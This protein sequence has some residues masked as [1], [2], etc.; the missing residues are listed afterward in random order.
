MRIRL[1]ACKRFALYLCTE[2]F[3]FKIEFA[4]LTLA[5]F[6]KRK[7]G[8]KVSKYECEELGGV[9]GSLTQVDLVVWRISPSREGEERDVQ[10]NFSRGVER[11]GFG[12]LLVYLRLLVL[13]GSEK[14]L[15]KKAEDCFSIGWVSVMQNKAFSQ[16]RIC[17]LIPKIF[18]SPLCCWIQ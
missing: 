17:R 14:S 10:Q 3:L 12:R 2:W 13:G 16:I 5:V 8:N 7:A 6:R 4:S 9:W 18:L 15:Q 11:K 1:W